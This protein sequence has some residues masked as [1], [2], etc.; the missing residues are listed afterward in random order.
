MSTTA[1]YYKLVVLNDN[2]TFLVYDYI[3]LAKAIGLM[4]KYNREGL[5]AT[6]KILGGTK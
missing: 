4:K 3:S 1:H 2:G 5:E 6:I